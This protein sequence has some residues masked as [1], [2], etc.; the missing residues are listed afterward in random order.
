MTT[1]FQTNAFEL[2]AFQIDADIGNLSV[3]D[4]LD[5]A[6]F[7]GRIP[8]TITGVLSVTDALDEAFFTATAGVVFDMHDGFTKEEIR[9]A[10]ELDKKMERARRRLEEAQKAQKVARKQAVRDLVDPKPIVKDNSPKVESVEKSK[11]EALADVIKASAAV[12]RIEMQ[13]AELERSIA[14]K[15][16]QV[17]IETE[18]AILNAKRLAELDDEEAL[19]LLL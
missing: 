6:S 10:K 17:R 9:R 12:K 13:Q 11:E 5:T 18:L 19:L 1:A 7:V 15:M 14:L 3:T 4:A 8:Q 16:E 2:D